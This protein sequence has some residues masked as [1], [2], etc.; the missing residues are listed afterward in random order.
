V[1]HTAGLVLRCGGCKGNFFW[2]FCQDVVSL[3]SEVIEKIGII[4]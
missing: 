1:L 2:L 3:R 4:I